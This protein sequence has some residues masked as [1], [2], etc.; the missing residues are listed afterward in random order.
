MRWDTTAVLASTT[1]IH[2]QTPEKLPGTDPYAES[3]GFK[4]DTSKVDSAR[5]PRHEVSQHCSKC[6]LWDGKPGADRFRKARRCSRLRRRAFFVSAHHGA[7][8]NAVS[9]CI[10]N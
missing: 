6:Q 1:W 9:T 8:E 5:Y 2:A 3:M 4:Y 7:R 10:D